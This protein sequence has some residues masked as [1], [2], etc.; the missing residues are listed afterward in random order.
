MARAGQWRLL[1]VAL[2]VIAGLYSCVPWTKSVGDAKMIDNGPFAATDRYVVDLGHVQLGER[3]TRTIQLSG[4]PSDNF[5]CGIEVTIPDTDWNWSSSA[6]PLDAVVSMRIANFNDKTL[7][8]IEAPLRD[9]TWNTRAGD[10]QVFLYRRDDP[11]STYF[12]AT[13]DT[14][15]RVTVSVVEPDTRHPDLVAKI[16][17]KSGGWK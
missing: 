17:M 2:L 14:N 6:K 11:N 3:S 8:A 4:L 16:T 10:R 12:D 13:H 7:F 15:Y 5:A 1:G 9:W